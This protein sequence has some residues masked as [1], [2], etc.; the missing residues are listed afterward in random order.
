MKFGRA[1][2][3]AVKIVLAT[4]PLYLVGVVFLIPLISSGNPVAVIVGFLLSLLGVAI[5]TYFILEE[6]EKISRET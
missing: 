2:I 1:I 5:N 6:A 3:V 4:L